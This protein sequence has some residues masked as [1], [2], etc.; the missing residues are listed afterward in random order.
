MKLKIPFFLFLGL[1][2]TTFAQENLNYQ[3]PSKSILELA[4]YERAPSVSMDTKKEYLLLSYRNTYKSLDDLNQDELRLGG[5]RINPTT[6]ISSTVTYINNLKLRKVSD[7]KEVQVSGLPENAKISNLSWSP[8]DKKISFSNTAA[9]GVELWVIDVVSAKAMK[10]TEA[11]VNANIGSPFSWLND[12]ETI[13]VKMLPKN[14]AALLDS[15]NDLPTG[16]IISNADGEKSQNRTYPDML[17]NKNDEANFENIM[18][19]ELYKVNLNGTATLFMKAD[20]YAGESFSPDGKYLM[21]NTIQK[22]FSYIVPL[23]RFPIKS[24]VYD[25]N[26]TEVK[27]VNEVPRT[28]IIPKGCM[29]VLKCKSNSSG[30]TYKPAT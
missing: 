15:K 4:D 29:A 3:K 11:N 21:V 14:R 16:P 13:L 1:S 5:L 25:N 6:N 2:L 9:K 10:L 8:N 20:M 18:T 19:S 7:K 26:G 23:S 27:V 30:I 24:T 22:P 12:N 17:K 28:E